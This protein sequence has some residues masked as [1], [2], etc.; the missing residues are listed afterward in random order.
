MQF[1]HCRPETNDRSANTLIADNIETLKQGVELIE[2]LD[3]RLYMQADRR[4]SLSGVGSH[5]RHCI[6]FYQ[7]F[8]AGIGLGRINYDNRERDERIENN[9][10]VA[11]AQ[12]NSIIAR[13]SQTLVINSTEEIE[14]LLEGPSNP[15]DDGYWSRS[16]LKR[17]LQFL[18]SHTIHHYAL[19]AVALRLHGFE[20]G[21]HFGVA[22]STLQ[23]WVTGD[24]VK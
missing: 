21:A 5:F 24:H 15:M 19:I 6:D 8:L 17:E 13:F 1:A 11:S 18:L 20:P 3:D 9:R 16:S 10:V 14:V 23:H 4:F 22:P 2:R 7:N 12:L